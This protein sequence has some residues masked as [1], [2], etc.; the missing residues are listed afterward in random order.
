IYTYWPDFDHCAHVRGCASDS[1]R[2]LLRVADAALADWAAGMAGCDVQLLVTADH[3][4]IDAPTEH[5]IELEQ[6]PS[7][8]DC[9]AAPLSGERRAVF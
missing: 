6:L 5:L 9:L 4:F 7:L 1:A 8:A 2:E 3:G